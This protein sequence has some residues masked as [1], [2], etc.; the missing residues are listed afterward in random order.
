MERITIITGHFGSGKSEITINLAR[1]LRQEGKKVGIVDIDIVNPYFC[2]RDLKEDLA[3]ENIEVISAKPEWSNAE[4]MVVPGEVSSIF[5]RHDTNFLLDIGGDDQGA[6]VL[7]QYRADFQKTP[8]SL[9]FVVNTARPLTPDEKGIREYILSIERSARLKV[10]HLIANTNLSDE[11]TVEDVLKGDAVVHSLAQELGL[12]HRYTVARRD[13]AED[14]QGKTL[15][16]LLPIDI[17]MKKPW[18]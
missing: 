5:V 11:T 17:F 8:Y 15:G 13:L 9:Y 18:S 16:E 12:V 6:L 14:L 10:T 7:G 2:I 1:K 3:R 4:L